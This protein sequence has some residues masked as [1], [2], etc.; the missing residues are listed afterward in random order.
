[1]L[2]VWLFGEKLPPKEKKLEHSSAASVVVG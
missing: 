1:M 2:T